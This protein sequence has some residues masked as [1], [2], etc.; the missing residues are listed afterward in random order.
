MLRLITLIFVL[1]ACHSNKKKAP[2][3]PSEYKEEDA[4]EALL[5]ELFE[6]DLDDLPEAGD[7]SDEIY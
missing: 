7:T 6:D 4:K 1:T 3:S 5:E 2:D